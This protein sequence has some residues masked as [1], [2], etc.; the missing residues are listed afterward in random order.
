MWRSKRQQVVARSS[1]Q[2]EFQVMALGFCELM[3]LKGLLRE[4]IS[5]SR[6]SHETILRQQGCN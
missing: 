6:G 3:W 2:A 5:E 4:T 1:A